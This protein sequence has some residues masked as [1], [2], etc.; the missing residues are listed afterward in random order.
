MASFRGLR[1]SREWA[2]SLTAAAR[3]GV[4]FVANSL[5]RTM[6]EQAELRRRYL[7]G[8]GPL[9][10]VPN[11]N[12]PHIRTGRPDHAADVAWTDGGVYRLAA[13]LRRQGARVYW[14]VPGE[15]WHI[16]VPRADLERLARKLADPFRLYPADERRWLREYDASLH[17]KPKTE[18][19]ARSGVERR[20]VLRRTMTARRKSIWRAAQ[21]SGWDKLQ[22]RA[23]YASLLDRT[24]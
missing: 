15:R 13:W 10:A 18:R 9:A 19:A 21:A 1:S 12:A 2:T 6:R 5:Q 23:R 7:A 3:D 4:R 22:R 16:E 17:A 24:K 14:T 11:R 8:L 20:R